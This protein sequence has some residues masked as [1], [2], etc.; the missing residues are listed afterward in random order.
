MGRRR[1]YH[2]PEERRLAANA[3]ARRSY[4]KH[5]TTISSRRKKETKKREHRGKRRKENPQCIQYWTARSLRLESK[6]QALVGNSAFKFL[7]SLYKDYM[8]SRESQPIFNHIAVVMHLQKKLKEFQARILQLS[9]A[10]DEWRAAEG[11]QKRVSSVLQ[12]L[13]DL[14]FYSTAED[15]VD[16]ELMH[17]SKEFLYQTVFA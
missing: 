10:G 17:R 3:K 15:Q 7:E 5:K 14:G 12:S 6:L 1:L 8:E 13:E 16:L 9:G 2:T 11:I 4:Q